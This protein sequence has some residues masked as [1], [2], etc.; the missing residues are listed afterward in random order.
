[1]TANEILGLAEID[2]TKNY[3]VQKHGRKQVSYQ[4]RGDETIKL[5]PNDT[6]ISV[7]LPDTTVS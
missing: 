7:P 4:D 1:M 3:L 6:F 5:H 2:A